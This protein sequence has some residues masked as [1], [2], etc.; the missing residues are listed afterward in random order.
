[1]AT[2]K[3]SDELR[4]RELIELEHAFWNAMKVG[5]AQACARL[6]DRTAIVV[7]PQGILELERSDLGKLIEAESQTWKLERF[8]LDPSKVKF[9]QLTD[10]LAI[11][12]YE[13]EEQIVVE[14]RPRT[15][16][17]F[18]TTVWVRKLGKWVC[19]LHTE[20]LAGDPFGRDRTAH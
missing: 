10:D 7:G 15:L 19:A 11:V 16:T 3:K 12:A 5:D 8:D 20:T 6:S 17:A 1:M 9:K 13:I 14:G 4:R 18:D 2:P